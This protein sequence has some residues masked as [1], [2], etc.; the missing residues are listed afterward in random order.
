VD[1]RITPGFRLHNFWQE[2]SMHG[3]PFMLVI[4]RLSVS[5]VG[6][7]DIFQI[8]DAY[9]E[10]PRTPLMMPPDLRQVYGGRLAHLITLHFGVNPS[11]RNP[12]EQFKVNI[13]LVDQFSRPHKIKGLSFSHMGGPGWDILKQQVE[14][15]ATK[16][17]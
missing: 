13:V 15:E 11:V 7:T 4:C 14:A 12:G 8:L 10:K 5:N 1:L 9:I 17:K 2:A 6:P 16:A 3:K